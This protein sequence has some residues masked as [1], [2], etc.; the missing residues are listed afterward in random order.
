MRQVRGS[1]T[2]L[3]S[4]RL[5]RAGWSVLAVVVS[6]GA[7]VSC[8]P[9]GSSTAKDGAVQ[10]GLRPV[11][12]RRLRKT[13]LVP[14]TAAGRPTARSHS[15]SRSGLPIARPRPRP[16]LGP[17]PGQL[18]AQKRLWGT[19]IRGDVFRVLYHSRTTRD[20]DVGVT[21]LVILP[22]GAS[23]LGGWPV[24]AYGHPTVGSADDCAPSAHPERAPI[25]VWN[26]VLD[27]NIAIAATDYEGL[28][29]PGRHPYLVGPSEARS[30]ID[31]VRVARQISGGQVGTRYVAWGHS[32]GGQAAVFAAT[33]NARWAPEL[34]LLGVVAVSPVSDLRVFFGA[35]ALLDPDTF[36]LLLASGFSA[37]YPQADPSL[38]L[39]AEAV[40]RLP[41]V[42]ARCQ[43]ASS[44]VGIPGRVTYKAPWNSTVWRHLLEVNSIGDQRLHVPI[45]L[46]QGLADT[47]IPADETFRLLSRLCTAGNRVT[48]RF[49]PGLDHGTILPG[50]IA[51][52]LPWIED[53]F[54]S[55]HA[56]SDCPA[57]RTRLMGRPVV[58]LPAGPGQLPVAR[59]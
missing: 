21:G 8:E 55:R 35:G 43:F 44:F 53:R 17:P 4:G 48:A 52:Y 36:S 6:A 19:R 58:T 41:L 5:R 29:G 37:A 22:H 39:R 57:P 9:L 49:L 59:Q 42:D 34:Q 38:Y 47:L 18:I 25:D 23:P 40:R 26:A 45:L 30:M 1:V 11:P 24:V 51:K 27:R 33:A 2:R 31:V 20:V 15:G 13:T 54:N 16:L 14:T 3:S 50:S 46:T 10:G 28:G 7:L 56:N 12:A 32:Q